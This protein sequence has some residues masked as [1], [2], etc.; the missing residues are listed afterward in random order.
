[1]TC[2]VQDYKACAYLVATQKPHRTLVCEFCNFIQKRHCLY[3]C[4]FTSYRQGSLIQT[5]PSS[6]HHCWTTPSQLPPAFHFH[7]SQ[8]GEQPMPGCE[9]C[10]TLNE[11]TLMDWHRKHFYACRPCICPG[12]DVLFRSS[13]CLRLCLTCNEWVCGACSMTQKGTSQTR[14]LVGATRAVLNRRRVSSR[15]LFVQTLRGGGWVH[16]HLGTADQALSGSLPQPSCGELRPGLLLFSGP[17]QEHKSTKTQCLVVTQM[18][19]RKRPA[20]VFASHTP[21]WENNIQLCSVQI[22]FST[23]LLA[24]TATGRDTAQNLV[25]LPPK[26]PPWKRKRRPETVSHFRHNFFTQTLN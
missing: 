19:K 1:M 24:A 2:I 17:A 9:F 14:T 15:V 21:R 16:R 10:N 8:P 13:P 26:P 6:F 20:A 12:M 7:H 18:C 25:S 23:Y 3:F 4:D 22:C 11:L 5:S